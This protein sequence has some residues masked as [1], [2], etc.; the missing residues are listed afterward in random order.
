MKPAKDISGES[1]ICVA[2]LAGSFIGDRTMKK[3]PLTQGQFAI[4]DDKNYERLNAHKWYALKSNRT[5]YAV[6]NSYKQKK[7]IYMHREILNTPPNTEVDHRNHNG[8]DNR[9]ENIRNCTRAENNGNQ[10]KTRGTS[11]YKGVYWNSEKKKWAAEIQC[12]GKR[13]KLGYFS[14]E[15]S[16]A[17]TYDA[18]AKKCFREFAYTNLQGE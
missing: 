6:R 14:S 18:A 4:V 1:S 8:L 17:Q 12:N 13:M 3:I 9:E 16:A 10:R 15:I 2:T 5:F 7:F 11:K